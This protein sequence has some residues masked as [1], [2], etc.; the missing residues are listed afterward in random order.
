MCT[1]CRYDLKELAKLIYLLNEK[2]D[3]IHIS[4]K[5]KESVI[6]IKYATA[7]G[8]AVQAKSFM[9]KLREGLKKTTKVWHLFN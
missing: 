9:E 4:I 2:S 7:S 5:E 3:V 8:V 6:K 1:N